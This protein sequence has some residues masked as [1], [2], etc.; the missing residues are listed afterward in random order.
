[1]RPTLDECQ[2]RLAQVERNDGYQ[3]C[4]RRAAHLSAAARTD[5][6][7]VL[8]PELISFVRRSLRSIWALEVLLFVRRHSPQSV[9]CDTIVREL[10]AT[11]VLVRRL[12]EQLTAEHLVVPESDEAVHF[13]ASTPE[14]ER[15]CELLDA[16]SRDRPIA[17]R[18]AII[19]SQ[20]AKLKNF[21]DAFRFTDKDGEK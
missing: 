3:K 2:L 16:A 12:V 15:L 20:D 18:E 21:S 5:L 13:H 4:R 9:R 6:L 1:M 14:L 11:P 8:D 19:G 7:I 17:L 10:R